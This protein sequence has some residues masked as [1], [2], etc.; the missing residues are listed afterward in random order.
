VLLENGNTM[1]VIVPPTQPLNLEV[2]KTITRITI[3]ECLSVFQS[4]DTNNG[5]L[6]AVTSSYQQEN[7]VDGFW[8]S[9]VGIP[10][11][12][13]VPLQT[14]YYQHTLPEGKNVLAR[15][16]SDSSEVARLAL[17]TRTKSYIMQIIR[18]IFDIYRLSL[19]EDTQDRAEDFISQYLTY[20][21][22]TVEDSLTYYDFSRLPNLFPRISKMMYSAS[23]ALEYAASWKTNMVTKTKIILHSRSF[24]EKMIQ[25]LRTYFKV[26]YLR[27]PSITRKIVNRYQSYL[28]FR[29]L[30]GVEVFTS[31]YDF[32]AWLEGRQA[33]KGE[34]YN[35]KN[36]VKIEDSDVKMPFLYEDTTD[37]TL[38]SETVESS[39]IYIIQNVN[40][41]DFNTRNFG[42]FG[43]PSEKQALKRALTLADTWLRLQ[44]NLGYDVDF[45]EGSAENI[46]RLRRV[47]TYGINS[48]DKLIPIKDSKLGGNTLIEILEYAG[49]EDIEEGKARYAAM[50]QLV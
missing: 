19:V 24:M 35:I 37:V 17:L 41:Y 44:L 5:K 3:D 27:Q 9:V 45:E 6:T 48:V 1:T 15:E 25:Y 2:T 38:P 18:W 31:R 33:I 20:N 30:P 42:A 36:I 43:L 21:E 26:N 4:Q 39:R 22:D 28:D 29:Q 46:M 16:G 8:F 11:G 40:G 50:L 10:H 49:K 13:Y 34:I 32:E 7:N 12:I 23:V 47:I 14:Q